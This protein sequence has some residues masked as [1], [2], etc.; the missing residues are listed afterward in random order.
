M[1]PALPSSSSV[2]ERPLVNLNP[3]DPNVGAMA[4]GVHL[5]AMRDVAR[6]AH[7]A[8]IKGVIWRYI[9]SSNNSALSWRVRGRAGDW[10]AAQGKI[11]CGGGGPG[12]CGEVAA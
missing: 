10:P 1:V 3:V 6:I 9:D 5:S 2:P 11:C 4:C 8:V 7:K 12:C